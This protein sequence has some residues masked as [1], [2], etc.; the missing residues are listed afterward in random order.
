MSNY[1]DAYRNAVKKFSIMS[2][3]GSAV[4]FAVVLINP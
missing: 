4:V 1:S 2:A 3:I